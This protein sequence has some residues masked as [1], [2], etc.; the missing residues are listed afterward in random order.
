MEVC[1]SSGRLDVWGVHPGRKQ[2]H[3]SLSHGNMLL[4]PWPRP[5]QAAA[6]GHDPLDVFL[7][8]LPTSSQAPFP[9][10]RNASFPCHSSAKPALVA[11]QLLGQISPGHATYASN[12][13]LSHALAH[14]TLL[15]KHL[16]PR[17]I[18]LVKARIPTRTPAK[19]HDNV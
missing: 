6:H 13:A 19:G 8:R 5:E 3:H 10:L 14:P 18:Q 16:R 12:A 11:K 2:Q 9:T 17:R 7:R 1:W 4:S 15:L